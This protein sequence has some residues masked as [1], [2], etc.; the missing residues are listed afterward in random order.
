MDTPSIST[1]ST[2]RPTVMALSTVPPR[3][4]NTTACTAGTH[5][6]AA[7]SA[8]T[9]SSAEQ[10]AGCTDTHPQQT[11]STNQSDINRALVVCRSRP[12]DRSS[13]FA[14]PF[15]QMENPETLFR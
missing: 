15:L 3:S 4:R 12:V 7:T 6:A 11:T 5:A 2:A 8:N 1:V 14:D 9:T 10:G 13:C